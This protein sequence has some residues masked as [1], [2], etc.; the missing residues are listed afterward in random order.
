MSTRFSR[1]TTKQ[2]AC[3]TTQG[4][5]TGQGILSTCEKARIDLANALIP[6]LHL[7]EKDPLFSA[8]DA[9]GKAYY[10]SDGHGRK[11]DLESYLASV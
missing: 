11:R 9:I 6:A 8:I 2:F 3:L 10:A 5:G 4:F 1:R 7:N